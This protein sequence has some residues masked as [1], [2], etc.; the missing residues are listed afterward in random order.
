MRSADDRAAGSQELVPDPEA[1]RRRV[2]HLERQI[3]T[4][5]AMTDA[6]PALIAYVD[7]EYRYVFHNEH[8][9][10]VFRLDG[11]LI[12]RRAPEVLGPEAWAIAA[13]RMEQALQ[14]ISSSYEHRFRLPIGERHLHAQYIPHIDATDGV[15][16]IYVLVTDVTEHKRAEEMMRQSER[17]VSLGFLAGGLAHEINNPIATI[18]LAADNAQTWFRRE[19]SDAVVADCLETIRRNARRCRDIVDN[20]ER[21][22][23]QESSEREP[24][25]VNALLD[26]AVRAIRPLLEK[27]GQ[28]IELGLAANL[29][30]ILVNPVEIEQALVNVLTNASHPTAGASSLGATTERDAE[31]ATITITDDGRGMSEHG[32][33]HLFDPFFTTRMGE[34]GTGLGLTVAHQI[35]AQHG[36]ELTVESHPGRGTRVSI[37]IPGGPE[38]ASERGRPAPPAKE[39][40][41]EDPG[42]R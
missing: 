38:P 13:P 12:G 4:L 40:H 25:P 18:L 8:Y 24:H 27:H 26:R 20:V 28:R 30:L 34:G 3:S 41:A 1:L 17:L 35:V 10:R 36:G 22:S 37:R 21:L 29:P 16:G 7:C 9:R 39:P 6:L 2:A 33:E 42:R 15:I 23:R 31:G 11:D 32:L 19:D 14:G 5:R